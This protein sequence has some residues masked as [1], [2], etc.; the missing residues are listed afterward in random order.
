MLQATPHIV[1]LNPENWDT[2]STDC[3]G[4]KLTHLQPVREVLGIVVW[5]SPRDP[6]VH[7]AVSRL[8]VISRQTIVWTR[9]RCARR[10]HQQGGYSAR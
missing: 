3:Q 9:G 1:R 4:N 10:A 8:E 2:K 5:I 6:S 7:L